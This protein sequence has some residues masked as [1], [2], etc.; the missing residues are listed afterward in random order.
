M[1]LGISCVFGYLGSQG[2]GGGPIPQRPGNLT[3][4]FRESF[5]MGGPF[6]G[7]PLRALNEVT[8]IQ[9]QSDFMYP[10]CSILS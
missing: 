6:S 1:A 10:S 5:V 7:L 4:R 3:G 2:K 8:I 9:I